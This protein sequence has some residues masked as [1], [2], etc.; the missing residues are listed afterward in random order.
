MKSTNV[1]NLL[2]FATFGFLIAFSQISIAGSNLMDSYPE[3]D[4]FLGEKLQEGELADAAHLLDVQIAE[5]RNQYYPGVA[6]RDA[7]TK[8]HGCVA[9]TLDVR[10]DIPDFLS[11]GVFQPGATYDALV[12]FSNG[13]PTANAPDINGDVRGMA[14]K[15][16]NVPGEKLFESP[17]NRDTHDF[18]FIS[19]PVF[20]INSIGKY[21]NFFSTFN[22]GTKLE[23]LEMPK[24]LGVSGTELLFKMLRQTIAN[25]L[26]TRYFSAVP[27]RLGVDEN[28]QAVKY[29]MEPCTEGKSQ[30]PDDPSPN[31]LREA[32]VETL[33]TGSACMNFMIQP[34]TSDS[35]DVEDSV[36]EWDERDAP[37][38]KVATLTIPQQEFNTSDLNTACE[39]RSYNPWNALPEHK[40]LGAI[41]RVR[42]IL[43]QAISELRHEMNGVTN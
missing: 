42:R 38:I 7:H 39:N 2:P 23:K 6:K 20:F 10:D 28:R 30:I 13:F 11:V 5:I 1:S 19:S 17:N 4:T 8:A 12:R 3:L 24:Y 25:P 9:A 16:L 22:N 31:Y 27:Y 36:T 18:V 35:M 33:S 34:R 29:S 41:S 21:A 37:F 32:M 14:L 43:Y 26:E 40:P 15:L